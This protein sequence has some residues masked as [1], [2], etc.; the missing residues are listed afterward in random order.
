[1]T[2]DPK[3]N[4]EFGLLADDEIVLTT[5]EALV[6]NGI[7]VHITENAEEAKKQVLEIIPLHSE[8]MNM[9]SVTLTAT[10]LEK[11]FV[12]SGNY[13]AVKNKLTRLDRN[14]QG[15]EMKKLGAAPEWAVGSFHAVTQSGHLFIASLTGSQ[16]PA[17]AYSAGNI[18]FVAGTQKIV[19]DFD[20]AIKRIYEYSYPLE[21]K[22][23]LLA[24]KI[25]SS[26]NKILII[27]KELVPGRITVVFV[28]EKIGY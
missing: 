5:A 27:N 20:Q 14:K 6:K 21:D 13:E 11:E 28:K 9:S 12:E 25:H 23:A 26:V 8:V 4:E 3:L 10:G 1:M 15:Q 24:Y 17:Y 7:T 16:I 19:K 22:R 2:D 18:V